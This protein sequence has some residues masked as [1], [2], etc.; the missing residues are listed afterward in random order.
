M[1]HHFQNNFSLLLELCHK[2]FNTIQ[3]S[4]STRP[5]KLKTW[6]RRI[7]HEA[8]TRSK[9]RIKLW[10]TSTDFF[11]KECHTIMKYIYLYTFK[12]K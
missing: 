5:T 7:L 9:F 6:I 4:L 3:E 1:I 11:F 12:L 8:S 2:I 10:D